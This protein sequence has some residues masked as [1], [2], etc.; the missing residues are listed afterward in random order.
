MQSH[1]QRCTPSGLRALALAVTFVLGAAASAV[2]QGPGTENGE[3]R[4]IGGDSWHTRYTP[5]NEITAEN[6]DE[7]E[8]VWEWNGSSFG[9]T[10]SRATP[11][12]VN[13]RLYTVAGERR[14]VVAIDPTTGET[15]WSFRE[16]HT[17]RYEY[18]MR[19]GYGKGVAYGEIDGRPVI[20]IA[21]PGFFLW[22]L[23]AETGQPLRD[24]GTGVDIPGF[25]KDHGV[26]DLLAD[27]IADW[28]PWVNSGLEYDP[29]QG[30]PLE[31][32]YITNSSPPIVVNGTVVVGNSAEQGYNQ[33]RQENVPG[34]I[35]A[36]DAR[37]GQHKW[38]FH[39]IPRPGEFGHDTWEN[40]AWE[41]TGDVSSWA[42]MSA[43]LE[44][45]IVYIP[46][47]PPTIDY[48]GGF[49]PG[50]NLFG[51]SLI[52]LDA[53]TGQRKWHFQLVHHD[54][55]NFD[56]PTAPV[57]MDVQ[58]NGRTVP[59]VAQATK[60]AFLY[61]F[62]RET[63]E[64]IWPIV[65]RPVPQSKVPGERLSPTQPFPTK[66][67]PYEMQELHPDSLIGFTPE[68]RAQALEFMEQFEYGPFFL[69][70][71]HRDNDTGKRGAVW[72]PGDGGG[73]NID[74]PAVA[75]PVNGIIFVSSRKACALNILIPGTERDEQLDLPTGR[76]PA[77]WVNGGGGG[78]RGP[79]G[80]PLFAPPYS[81]ITA[82]DLKTGE[83]LWWIPIGE[84][85]DRIRNHPALQGIDVGNTGTGGNAPMV[86]TP[87]MLVYASESSDG[88]PALF[89]IDK[90]TGR[91]LG[92]IPLPGPS[93]YGMSSWVHN[94]HQY[95]MV[96]LNT[97]YA[98]Y[99]MPSAAPA[100]GGGH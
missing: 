79:Q 93:R 57:L 13:G 80:L 100:A 58:Q 65:E 25:P 38:K 54:V 48:F 42:P 89:A 30:L 50:D 2:A 85:P 16:P 4:Y 35:L 8:P 6:F 45:N 40:D 17:Y 3:W 37:T 62:N 70:A 49:Q 32:G 61:V 21:T 29:Y 18:S 91:Q 23:D 1:P 24:W 94:G 92:K 55:W 81:R 41:W 82:I 76:T 47:N 77:A 43:D 51:T 83:H 87:N 34:D 10:T 33:S 7:L 99:A 14:H 75:D 53:S 69:P 67:A 9:P 27:L 46:T 5:A 39:V 15:L 73:L 20:Y 12:Y 59:I 28:G 52:A 84:T 56:T 68:L 98:A 78:L 64:P 97:G 95:I 31:L 72:C 60:Q 26:V 22:A 90:M 66:P 74:G 19:R 96:Q 11:L 71:L 44:R 36:Y 88:T 86:V 63:G